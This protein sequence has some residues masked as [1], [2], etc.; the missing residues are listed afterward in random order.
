MRSLTVLLLSLLVL[1][2]HVM[3][4]AAAED[5]SRPT[6]PDQFVVFTGTTMPFGD[7]EPVAQ[8]GAIYYDRVN[9]KLRIENAWMGDQRAFLADTKRNRAYL[10]NNGQCVTSII[11]GTIDPVSVSKRAARDREINSVRGVDVNRYHEV[12]REEEGLLH[13]DY[14]VRQSNFTVVEK[15]VD[16]RI[17]FW[18]P[19]RVTSHRVLR[20]E[21]I[22]SDSASQQ[23]NWRFFGE[24]VSDAIVRYGSDGKAL[25]R[26][27]RDVTVTVDFYN[28]V[29][30]APDPSVFDVPE[31]LCQGPPTE[32]FEED[33]DLFEVQRQLIELSF[34][35]EEGRRLMFQLWKSADGSHTLPDKPSAGTAGGG[36]GGDL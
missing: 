23:P 13:V 24:A 1:V 35:N 9:G 14:Y 21:L 33:I 8:S 4:A 30:M 15:K 6:L 20:Q 18:V 29:P 36:Q 3:Q 32:T 11:K 16:T 5:V 27:T 10:I 28:F 26:L 7:L 19:W 31:A 12:I 34:N 17:A 2:G 25:S 22:A